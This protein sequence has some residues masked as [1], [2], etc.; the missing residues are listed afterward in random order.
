M[1]VDTLIIGQGLA[2]SLLA[3]ELIKRGQRVLV[4]DD[5]NHISAS[6]IAAGIINPITGQRLVKSW[7]VDLL[8]PVALRCY[9]ALEHELGQSFYQSRAM[10]RL[11]QTEKQLAIWQQRQ[12]DPGYQPYLGKKFLPGG[13]SDKLLD[14]LGGFE[15]TQTGFLMMPELLAA[16]K[17]FFILQHSYHAGRV[18]YD[19]ISGDAEMLKW[20][21]FKAKNI[22]FCEGFNA[23]ANPWFAHLPY[24]PSKG[25]I[26]TFSS[27][28]DLSQ[29]IINDGH[30]LLPLGGNLYRAGATYSWDVLN[31]NSSEEG[32]QALTASIQRKLQQA[33]PLEIHQHN[34]GIRPGTKDKKP[35]IGRHPRI[36]R[37]AI[38]NGFGSKG[39]LMIPYYASR[40]CDHLLQGAPL[41]PEVDIKRFVTAGNS[42]VQRAHQRV[43]QAVNAGDAVIDA[44]LGN[45]HDTL[46]LA[47]HVGERGVVYGFDIQ[48]TALD[49]TEQRLK[50]AGKRQQVMLFKQGHENLAAVIPGHHHGNIAAVMFNLGYLPGLDKSALSAT[51]I[52]TTTITTKATT[53]PA[54]EQAAGL[55]KRN[56]VIVIV[57]YTGHPGGNE[58]TQAVKA[59]VRQWSDNQYEVEM[60]PLLNN[61]L[62]EQSGAPELIVIK[63]IA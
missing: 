32:R 13:V 58:E 12:E 50:R 11:F 7:Q 47:R 59:C 15:Q 20:H 3:Y 51:T 28:V 56:G 24:Q 41:P 27:K 25:E 55:L 14:P 9:R 33:A 62:P 19:T 16:L 57:A 43:E 35:F 54:L 4:V 49:Q 39:A 8:L 2:G 23:K 22:I 37:F 30:W 53:I 38:F 6:S 5:E 46:F 18:D 29:N 52:T 63:K 1:I 61:T 10:L 60:E 34:A 21:G 36:A 44:T 42:L 48:Q 17:H 31:Q 40:M 45:G 26:I